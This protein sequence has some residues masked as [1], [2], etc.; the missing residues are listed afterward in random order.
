MEGMDLTAVP[1]PVCSAVARISLASMLVLVF[2]KADGSKTLT[3]RRVGVAVRGMIM[4]AK[5]FGVEE[6]V[7]RVTGVMAMFTRIALRQ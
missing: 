4:A 6:V 7:T 2:I 1:P 5:T 3:A